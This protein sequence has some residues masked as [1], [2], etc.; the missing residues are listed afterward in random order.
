MK[1]APLST[2]TALSH[3]RIVTRALMLALGLAAGP[4]LAGQS[5][6]TEAPT[7]GI[8]KCHALH[9]SRSDDQGEVSSSRVNGRADWDVDYPS[10][11]APPDPRSSCVTEAIATGAPAANTSSD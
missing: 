5:V 7:H 11:L 1:T 4:L 2:R 6:A 8:L 10:Q 3:K 9:A